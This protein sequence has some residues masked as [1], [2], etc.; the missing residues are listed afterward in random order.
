MTLI[1]LNKRDVKA[2]MILS[3]QILTLNV[4]HVNFTGHFKMMEV[5][6]PK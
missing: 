3:H 5:H 2:L 6:R 4:W 1:I